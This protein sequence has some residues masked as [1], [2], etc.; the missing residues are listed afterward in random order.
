MAEDCKALSGVWAVALF[1]QKVV[2]AVK[3]EE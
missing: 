3:Y 1:V 2:L